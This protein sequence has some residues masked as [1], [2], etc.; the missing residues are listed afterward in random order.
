MR[1]YVPQP[2]AWFHPKNSLQEDTVVAMQNDFRALNKKQRDY[3]D[4]AKKRALESTAHHVRDWD[5]RPDAFVTG[6]LR[7]WTDEAWERFSRNKLPIWRRLLNALLPFH[8]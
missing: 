1:E 7:P 2:P 6:E 5:N 8:S 4:D 3:I